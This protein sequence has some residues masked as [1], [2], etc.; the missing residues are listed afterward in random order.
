MA[1]FNQGANELIGAYAQQQQQAIDDRQKGLDAYSKQ[2]D[3]DAQMSDSI[4]EQIKQATE[5]LQTNNDPKQRAAV[6]EAL[7][8]LQFH[9][10]ESSNPILA[11]RLVVQAEMAQQTPYVPKEAL[12]S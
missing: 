7:K 4:S 6:I 2:K 11:K 12:G 10:G 9:A 8:Q 3:A 5:I 1:Y